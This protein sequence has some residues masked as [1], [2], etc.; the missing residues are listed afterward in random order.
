MH[1][2]CF[3]VAFVFFPGSNIDIYAIYSEAHIHVNPQMG[4]LKHPNRLIFAK[5]E[6]YHHYGRPFLPEQF[7]HLVGF[8]NDIAEWIFSVY[9]SLVTEDL[10]YLGKLAYIIPERLE[11]DVRMSG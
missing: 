5:V 9:R 7:Q 1:A 6:I 8:L 10:S 2:S 4:I 3:I 11:A